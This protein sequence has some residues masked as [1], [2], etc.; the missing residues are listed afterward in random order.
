MIAINYNFPR[1]LFTVKPVN[2]YRTSRE[3]CW[4]LARMEWLSL[5]TEC[6]EQVEEII[7][8]VQVLGDIANDQKFAECYL[9]ALR[10]DR[11]DR[12]RYGDREPIR[13]QHSSHEY[14]SKGSQQLAVLE[15]LLSLRMKSVYYLDLWAR[16]E[17]AWDE[18]K[19]AEGKFNGQPPLFN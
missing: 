18:Y 5:W 2:H 4:M 6:S 14:W 17:K 3:M 1:N 15:M 12:V 11:Y 16:Q 7:Q 8:Q 19:F 10:D 9:Q 13:I